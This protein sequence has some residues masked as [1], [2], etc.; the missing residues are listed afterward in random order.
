LRCVARGAILLAA[1]GSGAQGDSL[2]RILIVCHPR[3]ETAFHTHNYVME[4]LAEAWRAHGHAVAVQFGWSQRP[5]ADLVIPHIDVTVLPPDAV[6][7]LAS[8][9]NVLNRRLTDISKRRISANL[10]ARR[11]AWD[12]PVIVKTDANHGGLPDR[13]RAPLPRQPSRWD[14]L[15]AA[16][17][18]KLPA[19]APQA[20]PIFAHR[21]LVPA[22]VW[23]ERSL[24]VERFLPERDGG[25]YVLRNW[26]LL[27][28]AV[29]DRRETMK[30]PVIARGNVASR[31]VEAV[32][33]PPALRALKAALGID[34]AK[35]DY[36]LHDGAPVVFDIA[37]T[38]TGRSIAHVPEYVDVL[39]A[40][41]D[42]F[43][44]AA[45]AP[46]ALARAE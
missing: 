32:T 13:Q 30:A 28:D 9:P 29:L 27:G 33:M 37:T 36:V 46:R 8:Y 38:P 25:L 41:I 34:Y 6:A 42:A 17:R 3:D 5:P 23:R 31:A 22:R 20:Y 2:A 19:V 26:W 7:F 4:S 1:R 15:R 11:D 10:V 44:P 39:A 12:G 24:V 16:L 45:A 40:G 21:A 18:G 43:L 35:I 14:R